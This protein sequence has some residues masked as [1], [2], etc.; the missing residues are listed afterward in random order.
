MTEEFQIGQRWYS[1]TEA[2]LGLGV[3]TGL[4]NRRVTL[5]FPATGEERTYAQSNAPLSRIVYPLGDMITDEDGLSMTVTRHEQSNGCVIYLGDDEAGNEQVIHEASL[6]SSVHFSKP[7]ERLFAGQIDKLRHY[8]L[9]QETLKLV[10]QHR[11]SDAYGLLGPRVELLPHQFYIASEVGKRE[12]PRVLLADEVGLGKTIEAG[13]ILHQQLVLGLARRVLIVVPDSL[14][15]Q[16]LV[17]MLR[18][19]NLLFTILDEGRCVDAEGNPFESAQLVLSPLSLFSRDETYLQQAVAAGWDLMVVDEAHHL[20]WSETGAS[21]AYQC[22]ERL[23]EHSR[24]LLLLTATPEQLGVESHFARLRLLD[25]DRYYDLEKFIAEEQAFSCVNQLIETLQQPESWERSLSDP[26]FTRLLHQYLGDEM[27]GQLEQHKNDDSEARDQLI[28][29]TVDRLLDQHGTGRVLFRNTR[30]SVSG[31]PQRI[32]HTYELTMPEAY[33]PL[34]ADAPMEQR[35]HPETLIGDGQGS[36]WLLEDNRADWLIRWLDDY[37]NS[38]VLVICAHAQTAITLEKQL[39]LFEGK[40]TALFHEGMSL[41]ERDRAAAYFAE[42]EEGAQL[43][44]CS[45]IGSE[46]RNF[47]FAQHMVMFD[48]PLNPDLLEQRIGRLDRIGQ[49]RDVNIHVPYFTDSAQ[50]VLLRWFAEGLGAFEQVCPTGQTLMRDFAPA[51]HQCMEQPEDQVQLEQLIGET[52]SAQQALLQ[53]LQEGRDRLLELNS[54]KPEV[55][56]SLL[57]AV[58]EDSQAGQLSSY[59]GRVF[60][61]FGVEQETTGAAGVI[62]HPGDHMLNAHFPGLPEDGMTGTFLRSEALSREDMHFLSW[63]HPMVSGAMEM[64]LEGS[65]GSSTLCTMKLLPLKA[66][67]LLIEA[68]FRIHCITDSTLQLQRYLPEAFVRRVIDSSGNDLSGVITEQ[69]F[70]TLGKRVGKNV[71]YNL[72]KHT[73]EEISQLVDKLESGLLDTEQTLL[74]EARE[75]VTRHL[76]AERSR[77]E[78]LAAVNPNIR[79]EEISALQRQEDDLLQ[80][81]AGASLKM[82]AIRVAVVTHD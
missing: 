6:E 26:E 35:L 31:F 42:P 40:R 7:Y 2:E 11:N 59:M 27:A 5:M 48:L 68:I 75:K 4:V 78:A 45:E 77:L 24:G 39:R 47:Q 72:V 32:L 13:L 74:D 55:A 65:Y 56:E 60:D 22:V 9:R 17:E 36:A 33:R 67:S 69:H 20:G 52:A 53:Q 10:H 61:H 41:L 16:W 8:E 73:R 37:R 19:F 14:I 28:Q 71:A 21:H 44:I 34:V 58:K 81:L 23:A 51:L 25:P 50:A 43:L 46:G 18:R 66:G 49:L 63:E 38:K 57:D 54:C 82:D 1:Y 62:L 70:A 30:D 15:H 29:A 76:Q 79:D 64:M 12:A 80:A 3:V